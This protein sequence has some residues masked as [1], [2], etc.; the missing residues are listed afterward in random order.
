[1]WAGSTRKDSISEKT[2]TMM[3]TVGICQAIL[4]GSPPMAAKGAKASTVVSA[5][6]VTGASISRAPVRA[7]SPGGSPWACLT[8]M[9]SETTT[10][11]S[12][13]MPSTMIKPVSAN[14]LSVMPKTGNRIM[15]ARNTT[16]MPTRIQTAGPGRTKVNSTAVTS[17]KPIRPLLNISAMRLLTMMDSSLVSVTRTDSGRSIAATS[18]RT[19]STAS[20]MS[21]VSR[22]WISRVTPR[23][24]LVWAMMPVSSRPD[25]MRAMSRMRTAPP[26]ASKRRIASPTSVG[27]SKRL[28]IT[29]C[30]RSTGL[31][32]M[33]PVLETLRSRTAAMTSVRV[34]P[35]SRARTGSTSTRTS[36]S[37]SPTTVTLA[38]SGSRSKRSSTASAASISGS[39]GPSR[40]TSSTVMR[41][42]LYC[43]RM[44]SS[45][46]SAGNSVIASMAARRSVSA[47]SVCARL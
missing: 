36:G 29:T 8:T 34:M 25:S 9:R 2:S 7:A 39:S 41:A 47:S 15:V 21:A 35:C 5:A 20:T 12:T 26:W 32:S 31:S 23:W 42:G 18:V 27:S 33:P 22:F 24:P 11:S 4:P 3:T 45:S 14:R 19:C 40:A 13:T 38:M 10:A 28:H 44:G 37:G 30:R 6:A 16:G 43:L 17:T 46:I 1:M